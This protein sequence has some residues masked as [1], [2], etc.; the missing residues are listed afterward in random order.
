MAQRQQQQQQA[1]APLGFDAPKGIAAKLFLCLFCL[2]SPAL[3][4]A[5]DAVKRTAAGLALAS[6]IVIYVPFLIIPLW[7]LLMRLLYVAGHQTAAFV[8]LFVGGSLLYL[9]DSSAAAQLE[10]RAQRSAEVFTPEDA[11]DR[12]QTIPPPDVSCAA[13]T[14]AAGPATGGSGSSAAATQPAAGQP[15]QRPSGAAPPQQSIQMT[16]LASA[17]APVDPKLREVKM[18]VIKLEHALFGNELTPGDLGRDVIQ[19]RVSKLCEEVGV[20]FD[21]VA[22]RGYDDLLRLLRVVEEAFGVE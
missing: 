15:A 4:D 11:A 22:A 13:A 19:Q 20:T 1:I 18:K 5:R 6:R 7:L 14:K 21:Y 10:V 9:A 17:V 8:V 3:L 2:P 16:S 12:L